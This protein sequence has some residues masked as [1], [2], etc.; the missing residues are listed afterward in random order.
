MNMKCK[1]LFLILIIGTI[2]TVSTLLQSCEEKG[3]SYFKGD[4]ITIEK[5]DQEVML[6]STKVELDDIYEGRP[7]VCDSFLIFNNF[8]CPDYYFYA[9][10]IKSGKHIASFC[11]K[12]EGPDGFFS[13]DES[14][15]LL[16]EN[17]ESKIW[18]RDYNKQNIHLIN[19]TQSITQQKTVTDSVIPFE[20]SKHFQY[21]LLSVFFLDGREILGINQCEDSYSEGKKYT[22]R[23]LYLFKGTFDNRI[24]EYHLYKRPVICQD[25]RVIFEPFE[26]YNAVYRIKPDNTKLAI[27]MKMLGQISIIDIKTGEQKNYRMKE[28]LTFSD[29]EKD[30]YKSRR[31]YGTMAV[32]DQYI[33]ALYIDVAMKDTPPPYGGRIIHVFTWNGEPA[34]KINVNESIK[35]MAVDISNHILYATDLEDNLYSYDISK[36]Q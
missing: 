35:D 7:F 17:G 11:P 25:R 12:G 23:D 28:S 4:I 31:Y 36:I 9:F 8:K 22:P 13:C 26:F 18:V 14:V 16:R 6:N 2:I 24:K 5:F 19:L 29:I 3:D 1:I 10:N 20:W 34:Y 15:Q 21:P 27:A 33:F 32:S 30:I